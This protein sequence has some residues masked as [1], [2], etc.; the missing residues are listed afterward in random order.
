MPHAWGEKVQRRAFLQK[1]TGKV[2]F[3]GCDAAYLTNIHSE[4]E[5]HQDYFKADDRRNWDKEFGIRHYAGK[6]TYKVEGFVDKN[7]DSQQDV[8]FD[9]L[10][11]SGKAFVQE[12][13]EFKDLLT[14][15]T[16]LGTDI[17]KGDGSLSKG[18]VKRMMTNKAKPTV[19]DAFRVQL[20]VLVDVLQSTNPW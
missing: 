9:Y 15:V 11:K 14:K 6:V 18:T 8:F 10:E 12:L 20:Q 7:R 17:N 13:C 4:F 1:V 2:Q 16:Q 3:Q 5:S 19:S